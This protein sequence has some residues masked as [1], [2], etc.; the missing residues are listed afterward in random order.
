M[1]LAAV[2]G[3]RHPFTGEAVKAYVVPRTGE[4]VTVEELTEHCS[5]HLARFKCP[6]II[7]IGPSLPHSVTGKIRKGQL[8]QDAQSELDRAEFAVRDTS[9]EAVETTENPS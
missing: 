9:I 8:R 7:E 1:A 2:V 4:E 5:K 3:V 6:S